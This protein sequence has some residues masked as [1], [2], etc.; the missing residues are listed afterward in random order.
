MFGAVAE[1][2]VRGATPHGGVERLVATEFL[3]FMSRCLEHTRRSAWQRAGP[4]SKLVHWQQHVLGGL[5]DHLVWCWL[6]MW[7]S[8]SVS[9]P[10]DGVTADQDFVCLRLLPL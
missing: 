8:I 5:T 3:Q 4:L 6:P 1:L 2:L 9:A 10:L 7:A